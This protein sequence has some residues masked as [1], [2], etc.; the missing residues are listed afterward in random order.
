MNNLQFQKII[1]GIDQ[2][3]FKT[4]KIIIDKV[5]DKYKKVPIQWEDI[6]YSFL[7]IVPSIIFQYDEKVGLTFKTYLGIQ[8]KFYTRTYIKH[9]ITNRYR[10]LN[11][12]HS[13]DQNFI[14][15]TLMDDNHEQETVDTNFVIDSSAFTLQEFLIFNKRYLAGKKIQEIE[16]ET[17]WNYYKINTLSKNIKSKIKKQIE[18]NNKQ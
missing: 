8:C 11:E 7:F 13:Y 17:N 10:I 1:L 6:Y 4:L 15:A 2:A 5:L 3:F 18:K 9:F 14:S 16:Q 12:S